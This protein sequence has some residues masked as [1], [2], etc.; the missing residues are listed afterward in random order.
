M[1]NQ[2]IFC[3]SCGMPL[4]KDEVIETNVDGSKNCDYCIYCY[5]EGAFTLDCTMEE[6][7]GISLTHMKEIFKDAPD[8][9]EQEALNNMN[10]F[11]PKLK[12]WMKNKTT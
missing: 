4:D 11:F 3:Q 8:F 1:D 9:N 2:M 6:M 7:I 10:S 5:K 12:R